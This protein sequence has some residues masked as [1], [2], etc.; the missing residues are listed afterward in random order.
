MTSVSKPPALPTPRR[1]LPTQRANLQCAVTAA[2]V[3]QRLQHPRDHLLNIQ[4]GPDILLLPDSP[5]TYRIIPDRPIRT[6]H[7]MHRRLR[8][9]LSYVT[10]PRLAVP[11]CWWCTILI[12]HRFSSA[13]A[14]AAA[15]STNVLLSALTM[16]LRLSRPQAGPAM[17]FV[18]LLRAVPDDGWQLMQLHPELRHSPHPGAVSLRTGRPGHL[19]VGE[20]KGRTQAG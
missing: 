7:T 2:Q 12:P 20:E 6:Q 15:A 10:S 1:A 8:V 14:L 16:H 5:L 18:R 13:A 17:S 11:R 19:R 4:I 3:S 9:C